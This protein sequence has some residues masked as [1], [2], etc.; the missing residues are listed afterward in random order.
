MKSEMELTAMRHQTDARS[1]ARGA[2]MA[3]KEGFLG[4][5]RGY[6][7]SAKLSHDLQAEIVLKL[8]N[9]Q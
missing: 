6:Q 1:F 4:P 5:A 8:L 3:L 9:N 2:Q 7:K